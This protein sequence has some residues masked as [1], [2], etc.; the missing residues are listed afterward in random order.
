MAEKSWS[1]Q[2]LLKFL[3][4]DQSR[5][6]KGK[7]AFVWHGTVET[8]N[9]FFACLG[10]KEG[11][12]IQLRG[13][14]NPHKFTSKAGW[15]CTWF[16][17][18]KTLLVQGKEA[19]VLQKKFEDVYQNPHG[20][21]AAKN[22][23]KLPSQ[24]ETKVKSATGKGV[25]ESLP[26]STN[27]ELPGSGFDET[28][29]PD[30]MLCGKLVKDVIAS[31]IAKWTK[32]K[33]K[34]VIATPFLDPEGLT[35]ITRCASGEADLTVF[36]RSVCYWNNQKI[37]QVFSDA[38][39][40]SHWIIE[41]IRALNKTL[42]FHGKFLAGEYEDRVD[43]VVTSCNVTKE[44]LNSEQLE[45][46]ERRTIGSEDFK[47][48]WLQPLQALFEGRNSRRFC[49]DVGGLSAHMENLVVTD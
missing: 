12:W 15:T 40:L 20:L 22:D 44:H 21:T 37:H 28:K 24:C 45:T 19:N 11:Y 16:S 31:K 46:L 47:T 8:L 3:D 23:E 4:L 38:N 36:V 29:I 2:E 5:T 48:K 13:N 1:C 7:Q 18:N 10:Y 34:I 33:A 9:L 27:I 49:R 26:N 32:D 6:E 35:F 39:V 42:S 43:L 17:S 41:R 30:G 25:C 14:G